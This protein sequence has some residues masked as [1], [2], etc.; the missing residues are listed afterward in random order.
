MGAAYKLAQLRKQ[1]ISYA[2]AIMS[3]SLSIALR[4]TALAIAKR[5]HG[6]PAKTL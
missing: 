5:K 3:P 1:G 2:T 4:C 6:Q